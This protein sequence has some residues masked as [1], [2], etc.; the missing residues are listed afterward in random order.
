MPDVIIEQ[1]PSPISKQQILDAAVLSNVI[2]LTVSVVKGFADKDTAGAI[3]NE[4]MTRQVL[5]NIV[6]SRIKETITA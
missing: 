1:Q 5:S 4:G 3:S 6:A 2:E